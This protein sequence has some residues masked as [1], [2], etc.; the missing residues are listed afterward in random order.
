MTFIF[1]L[2]LSPVRRRRTDGARS[3]NRKNQTSLPV[4]D[5]DDAHEHEREVHTTRQTCR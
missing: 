1:V 5:Y 3:R 2:V 4:L